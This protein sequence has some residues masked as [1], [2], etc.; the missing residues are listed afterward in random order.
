MLIGRSRAIGPLTATSS[1]GTARTAAT[2]AAS[3]YAASKAGLH[4]LPRSLA[5]EYGGGGL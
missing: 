2:A 5:R 3:L 1:V 4:G